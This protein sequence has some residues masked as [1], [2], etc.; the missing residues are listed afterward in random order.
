MGTTLILTLFNLFARFGK[1]LSS[2]WKVDQF[3]MIFMQDGQRDVSHINAIFIFIEVEKEYCNNGYYIV[4][5]H[6]S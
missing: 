2:S 6:K 1:L 5:I 3:Y 4:N